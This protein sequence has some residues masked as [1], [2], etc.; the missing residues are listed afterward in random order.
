MLKHDY[1]DLTRTVSLFATILFLCLVILSL[2]VFP[3]YFKALSCTNQTKGTVVLVNRDI[4]HDTVISSDYV[5]FITDGDLVK[6]IHID[7]SKV[8]LDVGD[9]VLVYYND[10]KTFYRIPNKFY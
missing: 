4:H 8:K 2:T 9:N 5:V 3:D 7:N 1:E 10:A 6:Y